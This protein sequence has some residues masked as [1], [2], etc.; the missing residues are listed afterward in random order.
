MLTAPSVLL[1]A[2]SACRVSVSVSDAVL[3][4]R[5]VSMTVPG[6][7]IV[8]VLVI[9]PVALGAIDA[10]TVYVAVPFRS[11]VTSSLIGPLPFA[12]PHA[13]PADATQ[14][15]AVKAMPAGG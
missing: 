12:L 6:T 5:L 4:A 13:D 14:V 8:A 10:V 1:I 9:V 15:Q 3:L 7:T 2:R 11:S